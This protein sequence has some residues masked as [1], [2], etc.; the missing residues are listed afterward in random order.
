MVGPVRGPAA[1]RSRTLW[2]EG[3]TAGIRV[4]GLAV[5]LA[6]AVLLLD[7]AVADRVG[8]LFD[9]AFVAACVGGALLVRPRDF[10]AVGVLP[11]LLMLGLFVV[12][13]AI[14]RE[15]LGGAGDGA[16]QAVV[17]GLSHHSIA[18]GVGYAL[19]LGVLGLRDRFAR[20]L[21]EP[22]GLERSVRTGRVGRPGVRTG[23]GRRRPP[24]APR[25]HPATSPPP[26]SAPQ[27][28]RPPR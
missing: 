25:E 5:V 23:P 9:L 11:P 12:A 27:G 3:H 26:S 22:G 18:L 4:V 7:L 21:I 10:F 2:E 6:G 15:A 19:C 17:S 14:H 8:V 20:G 13:A 24:A 1:S 28:S 16:V